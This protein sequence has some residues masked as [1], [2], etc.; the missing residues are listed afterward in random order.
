MAIT[1]LPD[2]MII[3]QRVLDA[4]TGKIV[5]QYKRHSDYV[6]SVA[7]SP[8]STYI[9]SGSKDNT[10]RIWNATSEIDFLTMPYT[11]VP[12]IKHTAPVRSVAWSPDGQYIASGSEDK[13][14]RVWN[15]TTGIDNPY[16][17]F[18]DH[19]GTVFSVAWSPDGKFIASGSEDHTVKVWNASTGNI[20]LTYSGHSDRVN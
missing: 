10:V 4:A 1:L 11:N 17:P 7:W 16:S 12:Y 13:T 19:T 3:S 20:V 8:D 18:T 15:A 9:A 5:L 6:K 14:V 2:G